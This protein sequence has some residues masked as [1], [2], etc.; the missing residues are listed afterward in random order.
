MPAQALLLEKSFLLLSCLPLADP[1]L[2]L[3]QTGIR[4]EKELIFRLVF[5]AFWP[6]LHLWRVLF[7]SPPT[8]GPAGHT[9]VEEVPFWGLFAHPCCAQVIPGTPFT[10]P[11]EPSWHLQRPHLP[12][13]A[14][15]CKPCSPVVPCPQNPLLCPLSQ[16]L[17]ACWPTFLQIKHFSNG[18]KL[19][20]HVLGIYSRE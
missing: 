19:L 17:P 3:G 11:Q 2:Y 12:C 20:K 4:S 18:L 10:F 16:H 5:C 15:R 9:R 8:T 14:L 6:W 7:E 13:Q 1:R